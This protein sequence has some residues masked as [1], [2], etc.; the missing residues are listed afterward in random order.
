MVGIVDTAFKEKQ[1]RGNSGSC[2]ATERGYI[3]KLMDAS[4]RET[5]TDPSERVGM[6]V[7]D[8]ILFNNDVIDDHM[9]IRISLPSDKVKMI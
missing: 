2:A 9:G 1:E 8:W 7:I 3:S 4:Y 5:P 6:T